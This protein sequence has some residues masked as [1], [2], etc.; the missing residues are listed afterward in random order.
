MKINTNHLYHGAALIQIAE[1]EKFTAINA[2]NIRGET[3]E[4]AFRI[5]QDEVVY[6]KYATK[7]K[8]PHSE[9]E[10]N[11]K[12]SQLSD[13][14]EISRHCSNIFIILVCVGAD[15]I[16]VLKK[17]QLDALIASR[18]VAKGARERQYTILVTAPR[19]KS[20]RVYMNSPG[21]K[22]KKLIP[23]LIVARNDFPNIIF[24]S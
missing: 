2:L 24:E 21:S 18:R 6:I 3:Y 14:I 15:E 9:Y 5:N 13:I 10:F 7:A 11:F 17:D 8:P 19:G 22:G 4:N 20:L 12:A 16:C 23:E 1:H